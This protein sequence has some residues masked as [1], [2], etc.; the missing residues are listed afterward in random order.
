M[1]LSSETCFENNAF[2]VIGGIPTPSPLHPSRQWNQ[3]SYCV[4]FLKDNSPE[5]QDLGSQ[6]SH[7][8]VLDNNY[9]FEVTTI[10]QRSFVNDSEASP[11]QKL[12]TG[13][14]HWQENNANIVH[15]TFCSG[16]S[17]IFACLW[18][19]FFWNDSS[20]NWK[21]LINRFQEYQIK[22]TKF[23]RIMF[24]CNVSIYGESSMWNRGTAT[25]LYNTYCAY[26][27]TFCVNDFTSEQ[28]KNLFHKIPCFFIKNI[29]YKNM[30]RN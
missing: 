5:I 11:L 9:A 30:T 25:Y 19:V 15:F 14:I 23:R 10:Y 26:F 12:K 29:K 7:G 22:E 24:L 2:K 27:P 8:W 4:A 28:K 17:S 20:I 3:R 1:I 6:V 21:F 18:K 16:F 13:E